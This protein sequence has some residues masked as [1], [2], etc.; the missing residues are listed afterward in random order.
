MLL[1]G[2]PETRATMAQATEG[3]AR[4]EPS[5]PQFGPEALQFSVHLPE[6]LLDATKTPRDYRGD[7]AKL[8]LVIGLAALNTDNHT[9]GPFGA[10]IFDGDSRLIAVGVN[11]VQQENASFA[12]AEMMAFLAA[13]RL[14]GRVR[15]ND[16]GQNY[17]LATSAQPCAMCFG[18]C[19]WAGISTLLVSARAEDVESLAGFDEGPIPENWI[20]AMAERGITVRRDILRAEGRAVLRIFSRRGAGTY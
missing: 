13:Q 5:A 10:A 18:G 15:L 19:L 20:E 12:H 16:D 9:G 17:T 14:T 4:Y 8:R 1:P 7:E 11:R 3:S 6:W 2:A